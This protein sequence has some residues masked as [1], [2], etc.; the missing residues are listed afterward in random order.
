VVAFCTADVFPL[1]TPRFSSITMPQ[2]IQPTASQDYLCN[3]D[4]TSTISLRRHQ[5]P[6]LH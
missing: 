1:A 3:G 2:V 5:P 6:G 4:V